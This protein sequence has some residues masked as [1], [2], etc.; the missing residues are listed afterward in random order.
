MKPHKVEPMIFT[1]EME[2]QRLRVSWLRVCYFALGVATCSFGK[3]F[4]PWWE[5]TGTALVFVVIGL[6]AGAIS[7]RKE[8][9]K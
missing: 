9:Q 5:E 4:S 8:R 3:V 6:F 1:A 2:R 7:R